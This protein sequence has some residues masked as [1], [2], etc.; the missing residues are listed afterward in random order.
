MT[1]IELTNLHKASREAFAKVKRNS[2]KLAWMDATRRMG[3]EV[4]AFEQD[5]AKYEAAYET[6][7]AAFRAALRSMNWDTEEVLEFLIEVGA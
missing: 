7:A 6:A 2:Q 1:R 5:L 3:A 4:I